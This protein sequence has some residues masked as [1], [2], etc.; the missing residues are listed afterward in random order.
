M[1]DDERHS[2]AIHIGYPE[3]LKK[4]GVGY[5]RVSPINHRL[6]G[7]L[8]LV[9]IVP[10]WISIPRA[11]LETAAGPL[12]SGIT[13]IPA[14]AFAF[15]PDGATLATSHPEGRVELRDSANALRVE[16]VLDPPGLSWVVAFSPDSRFLALGGAGPGVILCDLKPGGTQRHL[17]LPVNR[18]TTIAF[19]PDGQAL[20]AASERDNDIIVWDIATD[21]VRMRLRGHASPALSLAFTADGRSI[22]SGEKNEPVILIW[23]LDTGRPRLRLDVP[24]GPVNALACSPDGNWLAVVSGWSEV[25][26]WDWK[27]GR[28]DRRIERST[29]AATSIAFSS[30]GRLLGATGYDGS[31]RLWNI[32]TGREGPCLHGETSWLRS[33]AFSPDGRTLAAIAS[34]D[35]LRL[36]KQV[37]FSPAP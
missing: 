36:W 35:R 20:V 10:S 2:L 29:Q 14:V 34:D 31:A 6:V 8:V 22:V 7:L 15:S 1:R 23:D 4:A 26:L 16:R 30:D 27:S 21:R 18:I 11:E 28:F 5:S 9:L 33:M 24:R 17:G 25:R 3:G 32:A 13:R 19:S 37:D 12:A